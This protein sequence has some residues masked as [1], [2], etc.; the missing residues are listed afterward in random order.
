MA[1]RPRIFGYQT[2]LTLLFS[3]TVAACILNAIVTITAFIL[4]VRTRLADRS[5]RSPF[6]AEEHARRLAYLDRRESFYQSLHF[7]TLALFV[8]FG[9]LILIQLSTRLNHPMLTDVLPFSQRPDEILPTA[10]RPMSTVWL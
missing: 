5:E 7:I 6:D 3:I 4:Y 2:H 9:V 10:S 8:L 1:E